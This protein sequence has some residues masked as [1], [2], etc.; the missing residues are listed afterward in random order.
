MVCSKA[1]MQNLPGGTV[2]IRYK[3]QYGPVLL[4]T[5]HCISRIR[6]Y[7]SSSI[8]VTFTTLNLIVREVC[9]ASSVHVLF[10]SSHLF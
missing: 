4:G 6:K 1:V 7:A 10:C 2:G 3:T 9:M 8:L 5:E